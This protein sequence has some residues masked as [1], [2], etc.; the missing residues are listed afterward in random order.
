LPGTHIPIRHPD[1][2]KEDKPDYVM[3]L[4]WNI[5][6]EVMEQMAYI[7]DWGG[8]FVIPIP[9]VRVYG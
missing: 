8:Q 6:D 7:R 9:K 2:I 3:V 1:V 4:P 5:K